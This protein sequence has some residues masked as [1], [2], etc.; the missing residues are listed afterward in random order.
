MGVREMDRFPNDGRDRQGFARRMSPA[1]PGKLL[2]QGGRQRRRRRRWNG[3]P[4]PRTV[5]RRLR[6][7]RSRRSSSPGG[8]S[9]GAR[10]SEGGGAGVAHQA[11]IELGQ[12]ELEGGGQYGASGSSCC[13][14]SEK[15]N[16]EWSLICTGHNLLKL[17][18][19]G[20]LAPG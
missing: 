19:C 10:Q 18:R 17:F 1:D 4:I 12:L 14:A 7:R 3:I 20:R 16:G 6:R 15:V 9:G 11:G 2:A 8:L 5:G 13:G